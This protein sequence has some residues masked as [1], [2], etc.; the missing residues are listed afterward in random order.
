MQTC[1]CADMDLSYHFTSVVVP[2]C[3]YLVLQ[4]LL[5]YWDAGLLVSPLSPYFE[6]AAATAAE[7]QWVPVHLIELY[8]SPAPNSGGLSFNCCNLI[9]IRNFTL[10]DDVLLRGSDRMYRTVLIKS[11][12]II[13]IISHHKHRR[14]SGDDIR[15]TF[16]CR[17]A[18]LQLISE[19]ESAESLNRE[20]EVD[21]LRVFDFYTKTPQHEN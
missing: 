7:Y 15:C 3:T 21:S 5:V 4:R 9:S 19:R 18:R 11:D 16:K 14:P 17:S 2:S 12:I 10:D 20:S 13:S 1:C 8:V 6:P